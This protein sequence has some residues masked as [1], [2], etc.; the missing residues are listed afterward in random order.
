VSPRINAYGQAI[1]P[2]VADWTERPA[3]PRTPMLG[4][5]C[6][7]E[8]LDVERH[9]A[10]LWD[11]YSQETDA[12]DWTYLTIGPFAEAAGYRAFAAGAAQSED[13]LHHAVIDLATGKALGTLALARN[14][15]GNGVIEIAFVVYSQRLQRTRA[16]TEAVFL[17]LCRAFDTLGY[18]RVEWK[19]DALN[20]PSRAAAMRYGF[21]FEGIFRQAVIYRGRSR[22]TAWHSIIDPEWP[23]IRAAFDQWLAPENFDADGRQRRALAEIRAGLISA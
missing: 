17:L 2:P 12:R 10:D 16:G 8:K 3:P 23:A 1:G 15:R 21:S 9:A 20:A 5:Y 22:D 11:A 4:R 18:R 14:D 6:R 19:C 13:P 7:V